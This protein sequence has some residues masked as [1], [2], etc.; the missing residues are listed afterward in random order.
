MKILLTLVASLFALTAQ[1]QTTFENFT[2]EDHW[3]VLSEFGNIIYPGEFFCTGGGEPSGLFTCEGGNGI[4]IRNT[5]MISCTV[6]P[7][8]NDARLEGIVWFDI[9]ANWDLDYTGPVSGTWMIV[10]G[11]CHMGALDDPYTFWAGT[12][13]GKREVVPDSD[14][15][16]NPLKMKWITTLKLVGNGMGDL[17]GQKIKATEVITTFS[18]VP[19]PWELVPFV[20]ADGPE[21]EVDI[22]IITKY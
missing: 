15:P 13:T 8:T 22:T 20:P 10:P 4:H 1:A 5:E 18:P 2:V 21:G 3:P 14:N 9:A 7:M 19:V 17:V 6:E 11:P 16:Y 12:Y